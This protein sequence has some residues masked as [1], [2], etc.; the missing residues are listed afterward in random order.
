MGRLAVHAGGLHEG[1]R[2]AVIGPGGE[3]AF[4]LRKKSLESDRRG[5]GWAAGASV[6]PTMPA[7]LAARTVRVIE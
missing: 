5:G 1:Q 4:R 6:V 7:M 3:A 2:T